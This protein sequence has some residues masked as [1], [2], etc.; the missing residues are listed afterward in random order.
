M[1]I[2]ATLLQ[3]RSVDEQMV[4]V[5]MDG[6]RLEVTGLAESSRL[7]L[8]A[9]ELQKLT[10]FVLKE[11]GLCRGP[12]C[13]PVKPQNRDELVWDRQGESLVN[14]TELARRL[15]RVVAKSDD[16][17]VWWIGDPP[18]PPVA[19]AER[20]VAPDFTL[21]DLEGEKVS[22]SDFAGQKVLLVTWASW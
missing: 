15:R 17:A 1:F 13:L 21:P 6:K 20:P 11:E 12:V 16:P 22:L 9:S 14:L 18:R 7:W 8:G 2:L 4:D 3:I 19:A 5:T 10:G